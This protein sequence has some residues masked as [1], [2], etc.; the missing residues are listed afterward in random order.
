MLFGFHRPG[1]YQ[2]RIPDGCEEAPKQDLGISRDAFGLAKREGDDIRRLHSWLS[3]RHTHDHRADIEIIKKEL[4][5]DILE[6]FCL[7]PLP[8]SEDHKRLYLQGAAMDPDLNKYDAEH[9]CAAHPAMSKEEWTDLYNKAWAQYYTDDHVETIMR[10]A[11]VS[12]IKDIKI[13]QWISVFAGAA[14]IEGV[15]PL[16]FGLLRRKV[17]LDRRYGMPIA[18]PLSFY[19][20]R[21][22]HLL[23]G[24]L[25][26]LRL[27]W[28]YRRI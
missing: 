15:H 8:G 12:G 3:D 2:S 9:V 20:W 16:Q 28:H 14:R 23:K 26:W 24:T 5:I 10:R 6:F 11:A 7:T 21:S 25:A 22:F 1:K 17:R 19:T 27:V 4:P 13:L 18:N